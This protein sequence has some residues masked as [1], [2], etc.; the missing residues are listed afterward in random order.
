M[1]RFLENMPMA[2]GDGDGEVLK[3]GDDR[4]GEFYW[5]FGPYLWDSR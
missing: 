1:T 3:F 5:D 2:R 4:V